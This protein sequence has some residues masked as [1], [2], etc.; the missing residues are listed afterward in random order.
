MIQLINIIIFFIY[1][2]IHNNEV[3]ITNL[4]VR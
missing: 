3:I 4:Q 2:V 1:S